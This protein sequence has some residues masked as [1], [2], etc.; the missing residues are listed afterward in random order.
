[1]PTSTTIEPTAHTTTSNNHT[2]SADKTSI[3]RTFSALLKEHAA[4]TRIRRL[5]QVEVEAE[6]SS[7]PGKKG[8]QRRW[9]TFSSPFASR[10]APSSDGEGEGKGRYVVEDAE[11]EKGEKRSRGEGD[12]RRVSR[13]G[14]GVPV[15]VDRERRQRG[16][17][18]RFLEHKWAPDFLQ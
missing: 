5:S 14:G 8:K 16:M 6:S 12:R 10:A 17:M 4:A 9:S 1:M 2:R 18:K 15:F 13:Y 11:A 3:M 7:G